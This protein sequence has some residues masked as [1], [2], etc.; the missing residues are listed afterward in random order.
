MKL[1]CSSLFVAQDSYREKLACVERWGYEGIE[2]RLE[3]NEN[4]SK[5]VSEIKDA[6]AQSPV[7]V[8]S[9]IVRSPAYRAPL[10]S[11]EAS[12]AK[13]ATARIALEIGARLGAGVILQ[14]EYRPQIPLPLFDPPKPLSVR[15]KNL[16]LTFLRKVGEFAEKVSAVALLEPINRYET[17][18]YHRLEEAIA[19][20]DR[21][22][23]E[24]IKVCA[25]FFHM[26]IEERDIPTSIKN[27]AGYIHHIQLGDSNRRLPGQGHIDF[28][29]GFAALCHIGYDG[30]MS[31]ECMIPSDPEQELP[32]CARYLRRC[33][34]ESTGT[35]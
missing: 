8:S 3:E 26:N 2:V 1:A 16:L 11:E 14:P 34:K 32:A 4:L 10:D 30:F 24:R 17:H 6:L 18:Y 23:S 28:R 13:L 27:A 12:Q 35:T 5:E 22:G 7:K 15:E 21:V 25:D 29:A 9:I 31:L 20:C 33:I 19:L